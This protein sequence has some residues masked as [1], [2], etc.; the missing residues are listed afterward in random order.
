MVP[1]ARSGRI[2][3]QAQRARP[4]V[5]LVFAW[6]VACG[7]PAPEAP[8][9][10]AAPAPSAELAPAR[11]SLD[12]AWWLEV[13]ELGRHANE[14]GALAA[15]HAGT[16]DG[17]AHAREAAAL[18]RVLAL[19]DPNGADWVGRA[20]TWLGEAA[21]RR[22]LAG[23]CEAALEL[24][25]LEARDASD[26]GEAY[27][28]AFRT[29]L[30]FRDG[31]CVA[32][33]RRMMGILEPWRPSAA[34][35]ASIE[36]DPDAGDPT[37][38]LT[39]AEGEAAADPAEPTAASVAWA[40]ARAP[41]GGT[42]TL[43]EL[44][45]HGQGET[46]AARTAS[47]RAVLGFD[48]VVA[49]EHGEA[50]AQ[51]PLPRRTWLELP[52]VRAGEGVAEQLP[53]AAGGLIGVRT[54]AHAG[55]LRVTFDLEPT[56]RFRAFVLPDPFRVVLDVERDDTP[57]AARAV[58]TIVLDPGHGGD[59]HGARAFEMRES[60]LT[61]DLAQRVRTLL[62]GRLPDAR[63]I[64]TR[65]SDVFVSL[66]QRAAMA[67]AIDADLFLSVHLN[68]AEEPV[69]RGGV[70][71]F[72]LDTGNDRQALRLAARENGTSV[73]EVGE[74][75]RILASIHREEQVTASRAVAEQVHR[76][77]L[78]GG[79]RI[80]PRL[81]D[82]GVRS[83]MFY[84]LVGARMP[85]VLLEASFLSREEEARALSTSPYRQA[86]AEGIAEGIARWAR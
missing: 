27:R 8:S 6:I 86:L 35:L 38:A 26:A 5:A 63:V 51:G 40:A 60:D 21:R 45:V 65:E 61:L 50:L 47:V 83:A 49:F 33:A 15:E 7:E 71:T 42:A 57:R 69:D 28:V 31:A 16:V 44:A 74:L 70:T 12:E 46:D 75:S 2:L 85:A 34:Q 54:H 84:V 80:L 25:R 13:R 52:S 18:A 10:P 37:A 11:P 66:E 79:R 67:N 62:A 22:A 39:S 48:R 17:V 29:S 81:H 36:A 23:A 78:R 9:T 1:G 20:R 82:R 24:A 3:A 4:G 77:T 64:L 72:V 14:L 19:R 68:A 30:R 58:R 43:T 55:G 59:D 56:A 53:V 76:A 32:E 73:A 41:R